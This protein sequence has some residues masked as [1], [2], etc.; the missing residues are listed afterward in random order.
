MDT[1][2]P[3]PRPSEPI[4]RA[5]GQGRRAAPPGLSRQAALRHRLRFHH[6]RLPRIRVAWY[7]LLALVGAGANLGGGSAALLVFGSLIFGAGLLATL[8]GD[9]L[10]RRARDLERAA[11]LAEWSFVGDV[12]VGLFAIHLTGGV[13]SALVP[14]LL[15]PVLLQVARRPRRALLIGLGAAGAFAVYGTLVAL[16]GEGAVRDAWLS[17]AVL[18]LGAAAVAV[19]TREVENLRQV[20]VGVLRL[21]TAR[22]GDLERQVEDARSE[23]AWTGAAERARGEI[24]AEIGREIRTPMTSIIGLSKL[25]L[26]G[27]VD[28]T[29]RE[30][31]RCI[32][33]S[34]NSLLRTLDDLVDLAEI[35]A[36]TV[37]I[38]EEPF[39]LDEVLSDRLTA[40][41]ARA[42]EKGLSLHCRVAPDLRHGLL[43]DPQRLAQIIGRLVS[44]AIRDA[45]CGSIAVR[46]DRTLGGAIALRVTDTGSNYA[47]ERLQE[48]LVADPREEGGSGLGLGLPLVRR[49]V[50]AMG[51]ELSAVASPTGGA[52]FTVTLRLREVPESERPRPGVGRRVLLAVADAVDGAC[53]SEL[54][55]AS[56]ATLEQWWGGAVPD[57]ASAATGAPTLV[58]LDGAAVQSDALAF[59]RLI[60]AL[61][62]QRVVVVASH[63]DGATDEALR[64]F[65]GRVLRL[66]RP[67]LAPAFETLLENVAIAADR[68]AP[69]LPRMPRSGSAGGG[70]FG[71]PTPSAAIGVARRQAA[72]AQRVL[73]A[74][75]D[76][77]NRRLIRAVLEGW[78][79]EVVAVTNGEEAVLAFRDQTFDTV[80]MDLRL[81]VLDG[82]EATRQ[83]RA[84]SAAGATVPIL[85]LTASPLESEA[86]R[87]ADAGLDGYLSKPIE[88]PA[89][90]D[91]VELQGGRSGGGQRAAAIS[92]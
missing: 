58:V 13:D 34:A 28:P 45:E 65:E 77:A 89:L 42:F 21:A 90:F 25:C 37:E 12:A 17:S 60:E 7:A 53:L 3:Q 63:A 43:G 78:G 33:G 76:A 80:L 20:D 56:G 85:A 23:R 64:P 74:E 92:G 61:P 14:L 24:L 62:A 18:A 67:V 49:M 4:H 66:D 54:I 72:R 70:A 32:H 22:V 86:E 30:H 59:R 38:C 81:P 91:W 35:E 1:E 27:E 88:L 19:G 29:R 87:C 15:G 11:T 84:Q 83:L 41:E 51:G 31:L 8:V 16:G 48:L 71:L 2:N 10:P 75:D 55:D 44:N 69:A 79:H 6:E 40:L 5:P 57:A 73:L 36:G 46:A 68:P 50:E 26:E 52:D 9:R 82:F 39:S 47:D